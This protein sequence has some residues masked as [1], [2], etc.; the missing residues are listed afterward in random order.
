MVAEHCWLAATAIIHVAFR[1]KRTAQLFGRWCSMRCTELFNAGIIT[2][3]KK[4]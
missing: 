1:A 4:C 2:M 3:S